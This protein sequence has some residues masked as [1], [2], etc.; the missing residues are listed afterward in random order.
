M[1]S[2]KDFYTTTEEEKEQLSLIE[3]RGSRHA[4]P[5]IRMLAWKI[6]QVLNKEAPNLFDD[7]RWV[8]D[9]SYSDGRVWPAD[10]HTEYRKV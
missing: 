1:A 9:E 8:I 4:E 6:W 7:Y 10:V 2:R 5:E 3:M